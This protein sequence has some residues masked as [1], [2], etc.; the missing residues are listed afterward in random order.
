MNQKSASDRFGHL[1]TQRDLA[2]SEILENSKWANFIREGEFDR[3]LYGIY[4][5]ETYHYVIHNPRHQAMVG[6]GTKEPIFKYIKF[7][8]E[9]AEE[10]TGHEMMAFHDLLSLGYKKGSF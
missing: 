4:L 3:R 1:Q 10:E 9:H 5:I 6:A 8:Y 7:C 2:W